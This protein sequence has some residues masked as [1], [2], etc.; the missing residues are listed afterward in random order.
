MPDGYVTEG[1][2]EYKEKLRFLCD[3]FTAYNTNIQHL[4]IRIPCLCSLLPSKAALAKSHVVELLSPIRRLR[5]SH[6]TCFKITHDDR[7]HDQQARK[8][9][10]NSAAA[11]SLIKALEA[12]Y[13]QLEAEELSTK[14]RLWKDIKADDRVQKEP[15][16]SLVIEYIFDLW[17]WLS[18]PE[19][20]FEAAATAVKKTMV[21][22]LA[23]ENQHDHKREYVL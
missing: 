8:I 6:P 1:R 7:Y 10:H 14:E 17:D 13:G 18:L 12:R 19:E 15:A 22:L 4:T 5:V 2:E 23:E 21:G 3:T 11:E 9:T 20:S 16:R